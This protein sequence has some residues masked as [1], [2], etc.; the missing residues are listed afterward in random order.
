MSYSFVPKVSDTGAKPSSAGEAHAAPQVHTANKSHQ[1]EAHMGLRQ[2]MREDVE[3]VLDRDPSA[4]SRKDVV[5]YAT[6]LH[7]VWS[8]RIQHALW[9]RG[10]RGLAMWL[11]RRSRR[12]YGVEIHPA[13]RIGRRFVIDHGM[14]VVIGATAI[15]GDDVLIYQGVTLGMTGHHGGKRHPTLGNRVMVGANA[16]VLGNISVGDDAKVGAGAVVVQDVPAAATVV[17][18]PAHIINRCPV[19]QALVLRLFEDEDKND[20]SCAL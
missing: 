18:V 2:R 16:T 4:T 3:A 14:G 11:S 7:A 5:L 10:H 20:W 15:I 6:G 17:G 12:R 19:S 1:T 8:Y 9:E 13:A